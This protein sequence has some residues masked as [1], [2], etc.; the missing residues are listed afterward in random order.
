[1]KAAFAHRRKRSSIPCAT[2]DMNFILSPKHCSDWISLRPAGQR[3]CR[4]RTFS[5]S[6]VLLV[7]EVHVYAVARVHATSLSPQC[8]KEVVWIVP[9][10]ACRG[11]TIHIELSFQARSLCSQGWGL[12]D[13]PL[14]AT[15]SPAHP[16]ARRDM[17]SARARVFRGRALREHR[18]SSGPISLRL[19][20]LSFEMTVSLC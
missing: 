12:I 20:L 16:L 4:W 7:N 2:K 19:R 10:C 8:S 5:G 13:L 11:N 17:P 9:H 1:M 18:R 15:F 14:R 6:R 3:R